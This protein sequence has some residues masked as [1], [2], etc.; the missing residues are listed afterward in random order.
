MSRFERMAAM[1]DWAFEDMRLPASIRTGTRAALVLALPDADADLFFD[2][3]AFAE[4]WAQKVKTYLPGAAGPVRVLQQGRSAFFFAVEHAISLLERRECEAVVIGAVDSLCSPEVLRHLEGEGRLL[5]AEGHGTIPGEGAAFVLLERAGARRM[6]EETPPLGWMRGAATA[7]E[8]CHF[9]QDAPNTA[10]A[11]A[12]VFRQLR[13]RWSERADLLYT[14]E[15]GEPFWVAELSMAYLR[16]VP[17][18][19]EP[20]VRMLAA[21]S[22]GDLGAAAG[23]IMAGMGLLSLARLRRPAGTPPPVLLSYGSAERGHVGGCLMQAVR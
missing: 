3:E 13:H 11:L 10:Q 9:L 23:G 2:A 7:F 19:P 8:S 4:R 12:S 20:F 18:M 14:C 5:Q 21:S 1:S 6:A 17:L 15:T 16:N 22:F